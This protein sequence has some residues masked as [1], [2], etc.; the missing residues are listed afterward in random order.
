M[1]IIKGEVSIMKYM[2]FVVGMVFLFVG[3]VTCVRA[4]SRKAKAELYN[5]QGENVGVATLVEETDGVRVSILVW[6]LPPG[7]HGFHIHEVGKCEQPDFKSAGGHFNPYEK[8]HG[9][10]NLEG[11]HAGDSPNIQVGPDGTAT[12]V[13]LFPLVTLGDGKNFLFHTGGTALVIHAGQ[14]DQITD[15][16]GNSGARIACGV[17][18]KY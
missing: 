8:K 5:S 18:T 3:S 2:A 12:E 9:L 10:K 14:D 17:I 7:L 11:A 4:D 6:G 1:E 15:P 16:S 13:V